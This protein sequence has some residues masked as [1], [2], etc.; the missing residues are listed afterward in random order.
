MLIAVCIA[1]GGIQ[2]Q[3]LLT[4]GRSVLGGIEKQV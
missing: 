4:A 2:K 1:V 3:I